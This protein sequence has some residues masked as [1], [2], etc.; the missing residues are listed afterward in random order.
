MKVVSVENTYPL[1]TGCVYDV[2]KLRSVSP[3]LGYR[4]EDNLLYKISVNNI[5]YEFWSWR[6]K[7]YAYRNE[8][9]S[10]ILE[11]L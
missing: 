10:R 1:V 4:P 6:F 2:I 3:S 7:E 5:V 9:L 8:K 11:V